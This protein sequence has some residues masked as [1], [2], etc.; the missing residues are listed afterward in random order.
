M[1]DIYVQF[2]STQPIALK[3]TI[4]ISSRN[5]LQVYILRNRVQ[6]QWIA[7]E[8]AAFCKCHVSR[9]SF[10]PDITTKHEDIWRYIY[11]LTCGPG[12]LNGDRY[13]PR[14]HASMNN[15]YRVNIEIY[16]NRKFIIELG[17]PSDALKSWPSFR[18]RKRTTSCVGVSQKALECGCHNCFP[19]NVR[20]IWGCC[21]HAAIFMLMPL[22]HHHLHWL[23]VGLMTWSGFYR[24]YLTKSTC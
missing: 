19:L 1:S 8:L 4:N 14:I 9:T 7:S 2:K 5:T 15:W 20:S 22:S 23:L 12:T 21:S 17:P 6:R 16:S 10:A 24:S 3:I 13:T 11:H 18:A